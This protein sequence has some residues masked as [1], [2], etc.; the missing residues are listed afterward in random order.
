MDRKTN[1][2]KRRKKRNID[3]FQIEQDENFS[4]IVGYTSGGFPYGKKRIMSR[5][6]WKMYLFKNTMYYVIFKNG[7]CY[8]GCII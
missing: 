3:D 7:R 6:K 4:F 5:M 1:K 2:N 8:H